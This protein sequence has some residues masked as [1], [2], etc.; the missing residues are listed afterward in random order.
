MLSVRGMDG[1][2]ARSKVVTALRAVPG[3]VTADASSGQQVLVTYDGG[4]VT[5]MDLIRVLRRL[6]FLAG[7]A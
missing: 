6:G 7:M 3:V 4:D 1:D 2:D 5:V